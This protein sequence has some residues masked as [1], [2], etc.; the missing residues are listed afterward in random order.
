MK[1]RVIG[2]MGLA[3]MVASLLAATPVLAQAK[4]DGTEFLNAVRERDGT[5]ATEL[6]AKPGAVVVNT[7]EYT[8]GETPLHVVAQRR[9]L[10]WLKFLLNKGADPDAHDKAGVTPLQ[11]AVGLGW[12]EGVEALVAGGA[13][14]D[15]RNAIGETPL[16]AAVHRR[17][18][19]LVKVLL[20]A[21][22]DPDRTDN[23]GRTARE[24]AAL[25]GS[26]PMAEAI[27]A[28]STAQAARRADTYGPGA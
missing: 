20:D 18:L 22:A 16:I 1:K 13:A 6:L 9:D 25:M 12:T 11:I 23:S 26:G 21:G 8:S 7:R 4:S 2:I 24:Y 10:T 17:D 14:V 27:G 3:G 5:K 15:N 19:A 28:A